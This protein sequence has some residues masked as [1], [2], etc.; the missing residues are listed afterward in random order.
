LRWSPP[1][2]FNGEVFSSKSDVWSFG[3]TMWEIVEFG[4]EPYIGMSNT[5][6]VE[7]VRGGKRLQKP[8]NC[9][10]TWYKLMCDCWIVEPAKRPSFADI[11]VRLIQCLTEVSP[12]EGKILELDCVTSIHSGSS[13]SGSG[14]GYQTT[15][16]IV[17][18][19]ENDTYTPM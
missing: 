12:E 4:L 1:E 2:V 17:K 3:V 10:D 16:N 13:S 11:L 9:T 15:P 18:A 14:G 7:Y 6:V 8:S 5:E 19:P